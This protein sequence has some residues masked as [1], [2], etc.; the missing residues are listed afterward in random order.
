VV[1]IDL[2]IDADDVQGMLAKAIGKYIAKH[3]TAATAKKHP[4][5]TRIDLIYSLGD[6]VSTPWVYLNLDTKPGG[7]PDGN[8]THPD[9]AKLTR[10]D[11]L[12]AFRAVCEEE[13]V[14]VVR[15][16]GKSKKCDEAALRETIGKFLVDMLL[17]AREKGVFAGLP[18]ANRCELGVEDPTTGAFGWPAYDD[19]GKKN[20]V[21]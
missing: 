10:E 1:R 19:R 4:P 6:S 5:V 14:S 15:Q 18:T 17:E 11:W 2:R 21:K 3:K 13:T 16:D 12:P 20:L 8:P 7:E 9:F